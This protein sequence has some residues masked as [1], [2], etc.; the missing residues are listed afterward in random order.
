MMGEVTALTRQ[1]AA[2]DVYEGTAELIQQLA[3]TQP[4]HLFCARNLGAQCA[5][6]LGG[7]PGLVSY[8]VKANPEPRV[9][10]HLAA[11]GIRHFD[12]A[13]LGEIARIAS[14]APDATLHFNNPVK[15]EA[16]IQLA[17]RRYGVRSFALDDGAELAKI[18]RATD[19]ATDILLSVRFKLDHE[20]ASYDFG[21]KFGA[22]PDRAIT[23]L[24]AVAA[25]G[26]RAALAFHPGSQCADP[27]IYGRYVH[28]ASQIAAAAAVDI[29]Q[30]NVGGGFPEHYDNMQVPGL[31]SYFGAIDTAVRS[32]F[33]HPPQLVCEPGRAM[34]ASAVSSLTQVIHVR[35]DGHTLFLNDGVY[36]AL[37]EQTMVDLR[38]PVIVWRGGRRLV[39]DARSWRVFGPTCDPI[40]RVPG[41]LQLPGNI[42]PGDYL[43]FGLLGA[44]GSATATE[45]NGFSPAAY[46]NV[47]RGFGEA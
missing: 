6:F 31:E 25:T 40:D 35:E 3:P 17:Y 14:L 44:Y 2:S 46:V 23:L 7:F 9:I 4:V 37:L 12:V 41:E 13:S 33:S 47:R 42:R 39:G 45:F 5:R 16:D 28:K 24:R 27:K 21:S 36:G 26:A 34:V 10:S 18:Q 11:S 30:I 22:T 32:S 19:G 15:A 1:R 38:L 20:N 29:V 43:E 8:A